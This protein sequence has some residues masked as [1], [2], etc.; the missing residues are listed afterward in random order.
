MDAFELTKWVHILS[1]VVLFGTGMG[2]A[3]SMYATHLRGDVAAISVAAK[4]VVLADWLFTTPA[5]I[6]QPVTGAILVWLAGHAWTDLWIVLSLALYVLAG[7]CWLPVVWLQIK[8]SKFASDAVA[9]SEELPPEY[10]RY[11]R[12]WFVLGWPAF[13]SMVIIIWLMVTRPTL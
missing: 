11:M 9:R 10:H 7:A 12:Y 3:F 1:A 13:M 6:V 5:G 2:T 8:M 4:N